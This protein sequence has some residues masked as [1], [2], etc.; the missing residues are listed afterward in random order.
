MSFKATFVHGRA[1]SRDYTPPVTAVNAG[2]VVIVNSQVYIAHTDIPVG[3]LGALATQAG[4]GFYDVATSS[5]FADGDIVYWNNSTKVA[6]H[7]STGNSKLGYAEVANAT[8]STAVRIR[9]AA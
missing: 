7:S 1:V 8:G 9:F 4:V 3:S 6:T 5:V 2:D